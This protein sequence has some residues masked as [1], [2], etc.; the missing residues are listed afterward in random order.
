MSY[1]KGRRAFTLIELL[2]VIAI[3]AILAAILFPVFAQAREKARAISCM[4]NMKQMGTALFMYIQD[5]DETYP[6]AY[7]LAPEYCT[8]NCARFIWTVPLISD[9]AVDAAYERTIWAEALNSYIK[10]YQV[11]VCPSAGEKGDPIFGG[12][13]T[14]ADARGFIGS[15]TYNGYLHAWNIAGTSSTSDVIAVS[16]GAGKQGMYG[17]Q[18]SFPLPLNSDG[19]DMK[20]FSPGSIGNCGTAGGSFAFN[21]VTRRRTAQVHNGGQNFVYMDSHAK[22]QKTPGSN[23]PWASLPPSGIPGGAGGTTT[24]YGADPATGWCNTWY[25][26]FGPVR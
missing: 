24:R 12:G 16:E 8:T 17:A 6:L 20:Q 2:V 14:L 23:S 19:S 3:I 25:L 15:Y 21:V 18:L 9:S 7:A 13:V 4:S 26:Q 22:Y 5:Y 10:S 11:Y 1:S